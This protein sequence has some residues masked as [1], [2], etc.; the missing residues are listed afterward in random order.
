M[1]HTFVTILPG[2][3]VIYYPRD[4]LLFLLKKLLLEAENL[5]S[6][7]QCQGQCQVQVDLYQA[8]KFLFCK[9]HLPKRM[10][11]VK[12]KIRINK[13]TPFLFLE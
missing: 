12:D 8:S 1:Q 10:I 6:N 7:S 5:M 13:V 11:A 9:Y 4:I 3:M 2:A